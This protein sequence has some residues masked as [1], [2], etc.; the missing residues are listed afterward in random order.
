MHRAFRASGSQPAQ[1]PALLQQAE[2]VPW[3]VW[4]VSVLLEPRFQEVSAVL[5]WAVSV[6]SQQPSEDPV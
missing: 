2:L 1:R 5:A 6:V 3:A 4:Q